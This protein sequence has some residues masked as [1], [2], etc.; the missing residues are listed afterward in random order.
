MYIHGERPAKELSPVLVSAHYDSVSTGYGLL[1]SLPGSRP[2]ERSADCS[3]WDRCDRRWHRCRL[4]FANHKVFYSPGEQ[5]RK[6]A[7]TRTGGA[8]Q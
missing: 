7:Q 1:I 5:G 6:E 4:N 3:V 8:A 2:T